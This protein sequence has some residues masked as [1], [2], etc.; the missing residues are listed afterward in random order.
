MLARYSIYV[1][2]YVSIAHVVQVLLWYFTFYWNSIFEFRCLSAIKDI[3]KR[4]WLTIPK[5]HYSEGYR[6]RVRVRVNMVRFRVC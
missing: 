4:H 6:V 5:V 1:H 2:K 3:L